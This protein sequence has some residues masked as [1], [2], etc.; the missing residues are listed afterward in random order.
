[1]KDPNPILS[2]LSSISQLV[3]DLPKNTPFEAPKSYFTNFSEQISTKI[4][5]QETEKEALSPLLQSLKKE[6]PYTLPSDYHIQFRVDTSMN[7]TQV[8][9]LFNLKAVL[10]Y[11][12]A[13]SIIGII[14][15]FVFLFSINEKQ[16]QLAKSTDQSSI[17]ADAF[18][19][20][21]NDVISIEEDELVNT[22]E[23]SQSLLVQMDANM[24]REILSE[25]PENE[26]SNY[27]DINMNDDFNMN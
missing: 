27:I 9:K 1:M 24:V 7:E 3:A 19:M 21:L 16:I 18:A 12:V 20:F 13:A 6:N 10:K 5:T 14:T 11:A 17:S 22:L 26:I 8:V 15:T 23:D 2:E 25:I 4:K